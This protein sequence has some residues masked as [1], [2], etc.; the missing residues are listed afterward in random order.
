M[1]WL[2]KL[3]MRVAGHS[4]AEIRTTLRSSNGSRYH[5]WSRAFNFWMFHASS[6]FLEVE[7]C[8]C[9]VVYSQCCLDVNV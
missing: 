5:S 4:Q 7:V 8:T 6:D 9:S 3:V 2:Y 1:K